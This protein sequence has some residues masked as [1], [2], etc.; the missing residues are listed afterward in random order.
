ME[1]TQTLPTTDIATA[2][3]FQPL[4][5]VVYGAR[6]LNRLGELARELG[7]RRVLLV[8][9]PGLEAAGHPQ[10]A[11]SSLSAAGLDVMVFD[12]VEENPTT[13]HVDA[14][15]AVARANRID[16]LVAVGGGSAMDCAKG[17]N[18]LLTNG[19]R[20][21]DYWGSGKA[22]KP[23]LP[24]IG[25]PTTAGTGSEAQSFALIADPESH[26]KMA[27]GDKK[28][29]FQ[30]TILDPQLTITQP[31]RVTA[32]T[33]ID[34]ISHAVESFVTRNA[35]ALSRMFARE[36]WRLLEANYDTV[37]RE[38]ENL[39]GRAA[40]QLGAHLAGRA[41][42]NSM[43]G[44]THALANPLT[45]HYGLA[46][47]LAIGL[48]LPHVIRFN[49]TICG[50]S[51]AD[52]VGS[53]AATNGKAGQ[54]AEELAARIEQL[55]AA[56]GLPKRLSADCGVNRAILPVLADEAAEQWTGRFNPRPVGHAEFQQ[57][58]EA[59]F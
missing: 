57:L 5:R 52:L 15:L 11:A 3:D 40:M 26:M 4:T 47:G 46:H 44:A 33:G 24:A 50:A 41:I 13:R 37:L 22:A 8:T 58:Y 30:A 43:L 49:S 56:A 35:N 9:D 36:A 51:Y 19:G 45:A 20:M 14:G 31:P 27:C 48:M 29:A 55:A 38:P 25:V 21:Q 34:A 18:F 59:A 2:F 39:S 1:K 42:E 32:L 54:S 16:F 23:M 6:S 17:I 12:G 53:T 10:R 28:A 7:A